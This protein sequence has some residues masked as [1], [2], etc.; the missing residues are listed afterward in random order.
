MDWACTNG[1]D[2]A[3]P[4][5]NYAQ[6][7]LTCG[8]RFCSVYRGAQTGTIVEAGGF[9]GERPFGTNPGGVIVA[10]CSAY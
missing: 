1:G 10:A 6:W 9:N 3:P 4:G 2:S 8:A 5:Y 7:A